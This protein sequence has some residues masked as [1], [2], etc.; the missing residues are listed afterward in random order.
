MTHAAGHYE[1]WEEWKR[2]GSAQL[3][4][5]G[6]PKRIS[7]TEYDDWPRGRIV[8]EKPARRFIIYADLRLQK[9][10]VYDALKI[11][12]GLNNAAVI[13]VSDAHYR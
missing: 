13:V 3:V 1:R 2:L 5:L 11:A 7:W 10:D 12:F 9:P 8:Y 6:Y 4:A